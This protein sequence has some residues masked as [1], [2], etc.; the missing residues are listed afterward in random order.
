M[1]GAGLTD[2]LLSIF[3]CGQVDEPASSGAPYGSCS[4]SVVSF[5]LPAGGGTA[6]LQF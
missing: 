6:Q 1:L 4:L 5:G 3:Q 2:I